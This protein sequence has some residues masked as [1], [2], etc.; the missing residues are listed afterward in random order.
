MDRK[1]KIPDGMLKAAQDASSAAAMQGGCGIYPIRAC[2]EAALRWQD[3]VLRRMEE[4]V[5]GIEG[6]TAG[7]YAVA[8]QEVRRMF[9]AS[10][11]EIPEELKSL[12]W[13]HDPGGD[14][15]VEHNQQILEA[16]RLGQ[17]ARESK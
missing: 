13:E 9:L 4:N 11:E 17:K 7:G 6:M 10:E 2:L 15:N 3:A 1:L 14:Y 8:I 16:Y 5:T 12:M